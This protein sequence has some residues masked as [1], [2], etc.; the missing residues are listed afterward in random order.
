[1]T[2]NGICSSPSPSS[3]ASESSTQSED[4]PS[5]NNVSLLRKGI[6]KRTQSTDDSTPMRRLR[7]SESLDSSRRDGTLPRSSLVKTVSFSTTVSELI[8]PARPLPKDM[9]EYVETD[10]RAPE[11]RRPDQVIPRQEESP[12]RASIA[13]ADS[14]ERT[15]RESRQ[16]GQFEEEDKGKQMKNPE[17]RRDPNQ[18]KALREALAKLTVE[19][20]PQDED[21][22]EFGIPNL[23][24]CGNCLVGFAPVKKKKLMFVT[25]TERCLELYESEKAYRAGKCSKHLVDLA[26]TFNVHSDHFD[27]KL[28]KCLCLMGPDETICMRPEGGILTIEGWRR[29]IVKAVHEARRRKMD[30]IPRP[31]DIFDACYDIRVCMTPKNNDNYLNDIKTQGMTS[32]CT[33]VKEL[34][35][36][37]RLCLFPNSLAIVDICIEPTAFGLPPA[38]FPPFRAANMFILERS[39]VAYYGFKDGYF[40]IRIGKGSPYRGYE[41]LFQVE[42]ND[43]CKEIYSRIRVLIERDAE[44]R[45]QALAR[46]AEASDTPGMESLSVPSTLLHRTKLSLDSPVITPR[47]RRLLLGRD[48]LSFASLEKDDSAPSSPFA[49]YNRPRGSLGNFQLDHLS[50]FDQQRG[51][52]HSLGNVPIERFRLNVQRIPTMPNAKPQDAGL[53]EVLF[54]AY[55]MKKKNSTQSERGEIVIPDPERKMSDNRS[56]RPTDGKKEDSARPRLPPLKLDASKPSGEFLLSIQKEKERMEEA[57]RNGYDGKTHN[58]DGSLRDPN[59]KAFLDTICPPPAPPELVIAEKVAERSEYT[60]MG[61]ADWGKVEELSRDDYSDSGDSCYSSRRGTETQRSRPLQPHLACQ[62]P[63][64]AQSFGAKQLTFSNRL[65][66]TVNLPD[67]ERKISAAVQS[68]TSNQ[69]DLPNDDPR[70]R[71]FSLGSRNFFNMIGLNDFRRLVSK[72][73]R[74]TSPNQTSTSGISLN[75]SN[76]SPSASSNF[77]ASAEY[78]EH[79]RTESIGSSARSSPSKGYSTQRM[80]SPK[81]DDLMSIDFSKLG[82]KRNS[83]TDTRRFPFGGSGPGGSMDYNREKQEREEEEKRDREQKAMDLKR[84][85]MQEARELAAKKAEA[86]KKVEQKKQRKLEKER[87]REREKEL[88]REKKEEK[89]KD[90]D[91]DKDF[92]PKADSGIADCTPSSS[93]SGKKDGKD[94]EGKVS[95]YVDPEG[96]KFLADIK[97]RKKELENYGTTTSSTSSLSTIV[98]VEDN[99]SRKGSTDITQ[100]IAAIDINRRSSVCAELNRKPSVCTAIMEEREGEASESESRGEPSVAP[101]P[102]TRKPASTGSPFMSP[103]RRLKFLSFR[104]NN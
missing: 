16:Q 75:S 102:V 76:A 98:S 67:S 1:M 7:T 41:I 42:N 101:A 29:A 52:I 50:R 61:P 48:C 65:P 3:S 18:D 59:K 54:E 24:K 25:L 44:I 86:D 62:M 99:K 40:F 97:K 60:V 32:I 69:L 73:H 80:N 39:C 30:R 37:K 83:I 55:A 72:R 88:K 2:E 53:R 95:S 92:R 12:N 64:R 87:E 56:R 27:A 57:R 31:E 103:F 82:K 96:L 43:V 10:F 63:N 38:G 9:G 13:V 74:T 49:N 4:P 19:D 26:M 15:R 51:S 22:D 100:A 66:P 33:I 71:A 104:K 23:Y 47:D 46:R 5:E 70:K 89:E 36:K 77:L 28:K 14:D 8:L 94:G 85:E 21:P 35:G 79:N 58:P 17:K 81:E 11:T 78:L 84:K 6:L 93:F 68:S 91:H 20:L 90:H 45:K 34:L